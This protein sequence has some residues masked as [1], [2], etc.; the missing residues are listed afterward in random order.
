MVAHGVIL[1][2]CSFVA[3]GIGAAYR[4]PLTNLLGATGIGGYQLVFPIYVLV[5]SVTSSAMPVLLSRQIVKN[6]DFGY[7]VFYRALRLLALTGG[8]GALFLLAASYPLALAQGYADMAWGYVVI[9]PAVL[10]VAVAQAFRGWFSANLH[11]GV[12]SGATL[13]EQVVKLSGLGFAFW[14]S[15]WGTVYAVLGALA[16]VLLAEG[17]ALIW[18]YVAYFACGYRLGE[19]PAFVSAKPIWQSS[20]PIT[21]SNLVMPIVAGV[22]SLILVNLADAVGADRGNAVS[23]YGILTGAVGTVTTLPIVLTLAF[24]T[25]VVPVVS[26]AVARRR[27]EEVRRSSADTLW[28]VAALSMPCAVGLLMLSSPIVQLLYPRLT[29]AQLRYAALLLGIS[30]IGV[31]IIAL[32]Q[33]YNALLQAVE[34]SVTGA[35]QMAIGGVVKLVG[36]LALVPFLGMTGAAVAS[37]ACYVTVLVLHIFSYTR[38]TGRYTLAK[39]IAACSFACLCLSLTVWSLRRL[40]VNNALCVLLNVLLG[41][42]VYA[43]ILWC[44]H[45]AVWWRN[46][47]AST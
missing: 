26:R 14:L 18:Y 47:R 2:L 5:L 23:S 33:V 39:P 45:G 37:L 28:M 40:I 42:A 19:P 38:L 34:R 4:L 25:Y 36:N 1:M 7:A 11:T 6:A 46:R 29:E 15:K 10:F 8:V 22:D 24:V 32:Q 16:G 27:I 9:A 13:V 31:P 30:S 12:L 21:A 3:K 17:A 43:I 20:L 35:K 41:G 44:T